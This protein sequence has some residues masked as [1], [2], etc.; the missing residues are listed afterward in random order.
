METEKSAGAVV[1]F[2]GEQ[3]EYLLLLST[4][5]GFPKGRVEKGEDE[6][7][8]ALREVREESGLDV[9]LLDG[10]REL[11]EYW[12]Q[13]KG[14]RVHKEAAFFLAQA[15]TQAVRISWE[16]TDSLWLGYADAMERLKFSGQRELLRK[17]NESLLA[18]QSGRP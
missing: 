18:N 2:R 10:F 12:Y 9:S 16:H 13:R 17:A 1:F 3:V 5:W 14:V 7:T 15:H 6:K 4:Y 8:A 11:D